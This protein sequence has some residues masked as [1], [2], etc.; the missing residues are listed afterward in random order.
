MLAILVLLAQP[1]AAFTLVDLAAFDPTLRLDIRYATSDNFLGRPLY[2]QPRAFL[3]RPVAEDLQRAHR[4]LAAE[5]FGLLIFDAYR[6][7]SVTK[8]MWDLTPTARR[9][10]V[11]DPARGSNHN[12]GCA[13]DVSLFVLATDQPA[14]MPSAYDEMTPRAGGGYAGGPAEARARRDRL[15]AALEAVGFRAEHHE[16]WHFNHRTCATYPVLDVPFAELPA[17]LTPRPARP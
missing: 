11:A 6:P 17:A 13:V 1:P 5:G 2:P 8:L 9:G 14:E 12:R 10:F 3:Q 15:R 4:A 7:F 16:W